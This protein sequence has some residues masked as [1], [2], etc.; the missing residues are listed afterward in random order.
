LDRIESMAAFVKAVET[1]SFARAA[2][3]LGLSAPMVGKHVHSLEH[4]L[5]VRLINRTTRRQS[6]TEAGRTYYDQCRTILADIEAAETTASENLAEPQGRLRV[7]APSLLGRVCIAPIMLRMA[8]DFPKLKLEMSFTDD[9]VDLDGYDLAIRSIGEHHDAVAGGAG[10]MTRRLSTHRMLICGSPTY[11]AQRG[12]PVDLASVGAHETIAF[13][14][15]ARPQRWR[16]RDENGA[17]IDVEPHGRFVMDDL[18]A[19][20]DAAVAGLGVAWLPSWLVRERIEHRE[21]VSVPFPGRSYSYHNHA[22]WHK[23][24]PTPKIRIALDYLALELPRLM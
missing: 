23:G 15:I 2:D 12:Q 11:L 3:V 20:A 24:V 16:F 1:G 9:I 7:T 22:L 6:L 13:G 18:A 14:R 17:P 4:R 8:G 10:M 21:L 19:I 5:G